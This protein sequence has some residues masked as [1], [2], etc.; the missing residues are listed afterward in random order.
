MR[1]HFTSLRSQMTL[2]TTG[3]VL[4]VVILATVF[5]SSAQ[6][7]SEKKAATFVHSMLVQL[8]DSLDRIGNEMS[9]LGNAL[10][11]NEVL[12]QYYHAPTA[13][14]RMQYGKSFNGIPFVPQKLRNFP[15]ILEHRKI[16]TNPL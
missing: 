9:Y 13:I 5:Y 8:G 2:L 3:T 1:K 7:M 11:S 4:A 6:R 15:A 16:Q 12:Q 14:Q 10:H